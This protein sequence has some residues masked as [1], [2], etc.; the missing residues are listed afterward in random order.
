MLSLAVRNLALRYPSSTLSR[1]D[2]SSKATSNAAG[3][4]P[5][6]LYLAAR[7]PD[8]GHAAIAALVKD[9]QLV[10]EKALSQDGGPTN[11]VFKQLDVADGGSINEFSETLAKA[12][13]EQGLHV[14][15]NNA[16]ISIS[17]VGMLTGVLHC[18]KLRRSWCYCRTVRLMRN[19]AT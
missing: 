18:R 7:D 11:I 6:T 17:G 14:L 9:E 1:S 10:K 12:H 13:G 16:G 4:V 5:L 19:A 3:P 2:A 15:V 8:R